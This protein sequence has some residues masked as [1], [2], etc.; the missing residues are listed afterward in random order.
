MQKIGNVALAERDEEIMRW[1]DSQFL[2]AG[3][4]DLLCW[5]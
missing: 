3:E 2:A 1:E 5:E 4:R